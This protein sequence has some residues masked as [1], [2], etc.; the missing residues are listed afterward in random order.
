MSLENMK[1]MLDLSYRPSTLT[2]KDINDRVEGPEFNTR[3]EKG[4]DEIL[5]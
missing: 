1:R 5:N 4:N 3:P 2:K